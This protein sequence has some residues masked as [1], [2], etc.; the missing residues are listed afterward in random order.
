MMGLLLFSSAIP[1]MIALLFIIIFLQ[2]KILFV[3]V[4]KIMKIKFYI[5]LII[6]I[7]SYFSFYN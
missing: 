7:I 2:V 4:K 5:F 6:I 1:R 3:S